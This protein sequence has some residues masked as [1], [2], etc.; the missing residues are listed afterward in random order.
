M[1]PGF[2]Y[3]VAPRLEAPKPKTILDVFDKS[4]R[5]RSVSKRAFFGP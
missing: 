3:S 2:P 1:L 5:G 4:R